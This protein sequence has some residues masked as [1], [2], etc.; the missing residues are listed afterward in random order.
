MCYFGTITDLSSV[1]IMGLVMRGKMMKFVAGKY[2]TFIV[3]D[4]K[5]SIFIELM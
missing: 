4:L 5:E 3:S 2:A 1:N